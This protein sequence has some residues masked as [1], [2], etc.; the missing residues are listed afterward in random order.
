MIKFTAEAYEFC[1]LAVGKVTRDTVERDQ[2]NNGDLGPITPFRSKSYIT[3]ELCSMFN[4]EFVTLD[5]YIVEDIM[6]GDEVC[7]RATH[8]RIDNEDPVPLLEEDRDWLREEYPI[9]LTNCRVYL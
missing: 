9:L 2:I 6:N 7:N 8:Y 4:S 3:Q 5:G 1:L